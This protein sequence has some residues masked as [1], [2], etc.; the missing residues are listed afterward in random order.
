[1]R[2]SLT[3]VQGL[4]PAA[5]GEGAIPASPCLPPEGWSP[6]PCFSMR[7]CTVLPAT[8]PNYIASNKFEPVDGSHPEFLAAQAEVAHTVETLIGIRA[9]RARLKTAEVP[10]YEAHRIHGTS[11][12]RAFH[13]GLRIFRTIVSERL[14]RYRVRAN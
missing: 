10:C 2:R 9:R 8:V 7:P 12:L 1:M 4:A 6:Q 5:G 3:R 11:N 13:D 14:R